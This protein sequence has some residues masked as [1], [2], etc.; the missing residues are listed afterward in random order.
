MGG[1]LASALS[2][3]AV[4]VSN[5]TIKRDFRR[6]LDR[7]LRSEGDCRFCPKMFDNDIPMPDTGGL[8]ITLVTM[9]RHPNGRKC[10]IVGSPTTIWRYTGLDDPRFAEEGYVEAGFVDETLIPWTVIGSGFSADARLWEKAQMNG[11]LVL[12]NGVDLPVTYRIDEYSVAPIWELRENAIASVGTISNLGGILQAAD[13]RQIVESKHAELMSAISIGSAGQTGAQLQGVLARVDNGTP[14]VAGNT[15]T[16]ASSGFN[17]GAGF[18]GTVGYTYR[19]HNGV[20]RMVVSVTDSTHATLGGAPDVAELESFYRIFHNRLV[21]SGVD[22]TTL[23]DGFGIIDPVGLHLWWASGESREI[24]G[25]SGVQLVVNDDGHIPLGPVYLE[26]PAAFKTF[27]DYSFINR[28]TWRRM[29]AMPDKPRRWAAIYSGS[30][31][32]TSN[33]LTLDFPI[34]SIGM[35]GGDILIANNSN[36]LL[37]LAAAGNL[38]TTAVFSDGLRLEIKSGVIPRFYSAVAD[39]LTKSIED[40]ATA[41][42][43]VESTRAT[44]AAAQSAVADAREE[45]AVD[46]TNLA[47]KE[48]IVTLS[49]QADTAQAAWTAAQAALVAAIATHADALAKTL[50]SEDVLVQSL[51]AV[52]SI[53]NVFEDLQDDGSAILKMLALRGVMVIYKE[54][55]IFVSRYTGVTGAPWDSRLITI[56]KS[57]ALFYRNTVIEVDGLYHA[58]AAENEFKRFDMTN[59]VPLDLPVLQACQNLFFGQADVENMERI[60][61]FDNSITQEVYFCFPSESEDKA[62]RFE[63]AYNTA[64]TTSAEYTSG[65]T[66]ERYSTS[67]SLTILG[68]PTG[69]V[70]QYAMTRGDVQV[71]PGTA[72]KHLRHVTQ[73]A[74]T[75]PFNEGFIG[76]TIRFAN[77]LRFGIVKFL[78]DVSVEVEGTG[79]VVS[80]S[81]VIEPASY[82]RDGAAYKSVLQSG[83]DSFPDRYT[84]HE[85][86]EKKLNRYV[87]MFSSYSPDTPVNVTLRGGRNLNE[88]ADLF[89]VVVTPP[90]TLVPTIANEYFLGDRIEVDGINNPIEITGRIF[91]IAGAESRSFGRRVAA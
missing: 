33:V 23:V 17:S 62:L 7:E 87:P 5:Y 28:I 29:Q 53:A 65:A 57:S 60:F 41:T 50:A 78:S 67:E 79:N 38:P 63:Y 36:N 15:I 20:E 76:K 81:F 84:L 32:P 88:V 45:S 14:G 66:I 22:Y 90:E 59:Q 1:R 80:Q 54:T 48:S 56:P 70:L 39:A 85:H 91:H 3:E 52:G 58:Y 25:L 19:M 75:T 42:D 4:G 40:E 10:I 89:S 64:S 47:L 68:G 69:L 26:N 16:A 83:D 27:S 2:G 30:V 21:D 37:N 55:S 31:S 34:R 86:S 43:V 49:V 77:G 71:M 9:L 51:D 74:N 61:A 6:Y 35:D 73:S 11:Y 44:F 24:V 82:H 18:V 13:I 8:P 12:N 72:S 46:P